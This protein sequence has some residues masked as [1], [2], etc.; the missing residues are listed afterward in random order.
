MAS[1]QILNQGLDATKPGTSLL[2]RLSEGDS[3]VTG[4]IAL[5]RFVNKRKSEGIYL[6]V[7]P[8]APADFLTTYFTGHD[9]DMNKIQFIDTVTKTFLGKTVVD[10]RHVYT[11]SSLPMSALKAIDEVIIRKPQSEFL[12]LDSIT[13]MLKYHDKLTVVPFLQSLVRMIRDFKMSGIIFSYYGNEEA[14]IVD[15]AMQNCDIHVEL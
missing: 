11:D 12:F 3:L 8:N 1:T 14:L 13:A 10:E 6:T 5:D 4:M 2:I 9:I 7:N 15:E